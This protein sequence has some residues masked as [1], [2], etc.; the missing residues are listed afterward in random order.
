M[1]NKINHWCVVCGT[2]YHACD[3][4]DEIKSFT[5]WRALTDTVEHYQIFLILKQSNNGIID[6]EEAKSMLSGL[7]LSKRDTFKESAKNVL[8][9]IFKEEA[10][11]RKSVRK[12][13]V[14]DTVQNNDDIDGDVRIE[15]NAGNK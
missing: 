4:C 7:D 12:K 13:S 6:K 9:E 15:S 5:P 14:E 11:T 1:S 8:N 10:Q 2:G 3:T